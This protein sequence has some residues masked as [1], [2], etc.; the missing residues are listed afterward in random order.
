[1]HDPYAKGAGLQHPEI[2]GTFYT[3][4]HTVRH[5]ATEFCM[6]IKLDQKKILR[7][8]HA[9]ALVRNICE[10]NANARSLCIS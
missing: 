10:I 4:P 3:R 9:P 5:T 7:V 1:M 8:D 6:M 2:L